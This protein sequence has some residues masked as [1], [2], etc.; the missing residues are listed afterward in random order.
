MAVSAILRPMQARAP[1]PNGNE[2]YSGVDDASNHLS[3][4][5]SDGRGKCF[6]CIEATWFWVNIFVCLRHW[7][8]YRTTSCNNPTH[9]KLV[10]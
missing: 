5:N 3:G 9:E 7:F 2:V 1:E 10:F 8:L 4:R 6:S